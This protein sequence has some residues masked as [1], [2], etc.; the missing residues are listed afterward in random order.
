MLG[1]PSVHGDGESIGTLVWI[2]TNGDGLK[3]KGEPAAEGV[4]VKLFFDKD[5]DGTPERVVKTEATNRSGGSLFQ[6]LPPGNYSVSLELASM[7][8]GC[9]ELTRQ[10]AGGND[11]RSESVD[12]D[13]NTSTLRSDVITVDPSRKVLLRSDIGLIEAE[14]EP[15]YRG[16][17]TYPSFSGPIEADV[18]TLG[19]M[20]LAIREG[21]V[22]EKVGAEWISWYVRADQICQE[23][24]VIGHFQGQLRTEE[25]SSVGRKRLIGFPETLSAAGLGIGFRAEVSPDLVDRMVDERREVYPHYIGFYEM[26][27][28]GPPIDPW[29]NRA[30]WPPKERV[31]ILPH[32]FANLV[33]YDLKGKRE[34]PKGQV[35]FL[36]G[37]ENWEKSRQ[38]V[39]DITWDEQGFSEDGQFN[40]GGIITGILMFIRVEDGFDTMVE[41]LHHMQKK[42]YEP[43]TIEKAM[44]DFCDSVNAATDGKYAERLVKKWKMPEQAATTE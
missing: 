31:L 15:V 8:E 35:D 11:D 37:L 13:I 44:G 28:R 27:R 43:P 1:A 29:L 10:N 5:G 3:D 14:K 33:L 25:F 7:P 19:P 41:V 24:L 4:N 9:F 36:K 21:L 17:L 12:S 32:L 23:L 38:N 2:D 34:L 26:V 20:A 40:L 39:V 22:K 42:E 6:D 30:I 18:W 16:V